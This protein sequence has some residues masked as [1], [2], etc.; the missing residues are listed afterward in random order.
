M[1]SDD[2]PDCSSLVFRRDAR[3]MAL[4]AACIERLR[5]REKLREMDSRGL[6]DIGCTDVERRRECAKWFWQD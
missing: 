4:I 1:C 2:H 6:A 3:I 5:G